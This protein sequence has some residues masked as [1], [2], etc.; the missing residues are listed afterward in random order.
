MIRV[1]FPKLGE[2]P[3]QLT[4]ERWIPWEQVHAGGELTELEAPERP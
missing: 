4:L 2:F 3:N 1:R